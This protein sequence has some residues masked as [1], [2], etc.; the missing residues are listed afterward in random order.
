MK[1][2][3]GRR[4][5]MINELRAKHGRICWYCGYEITERDSVDHIHPKSRGGS[6]RK[7][8]LALTC[9]RCNLAKYKDDI[10]DLLKWLAHVRSSEFQCRIMG[11]LS[12]DEI[13]CLDEKEWDCLRKDFWEK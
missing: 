12:K 2:S 1:A 6:D 4:K 10:I 9:S 7:E 5:K 8:N 3:S 13:A 11:Q